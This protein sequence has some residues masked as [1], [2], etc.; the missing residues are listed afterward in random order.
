[1]SGKLAGRTAVITGGAGGIGLAIATRLAEEGANIAVADRK[2]S[3]E[4]KAIVESA[5]SRFLG[6]QCDISDESE[7]KKFAASVRETLGPADI[8]VNNAVIYRLFTFEELSFEDWKSFFAVNIHSY[9]LTAKAFLDDL[10]QSTC[11]RIINMSSTSYWLGAPGFAPYVSAKG[12][13]MGFTSALAADLGQYEIT[14]NAVAPS[15]VRTPATRNEPEEVFAFIKSRQ[16]LPRE[17]SAEDVANMV[18][19]LA[20][21]EA[22]FVTGQ[23]MVVDGG[24][25]RR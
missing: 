12:A 9:F 3:D 7:V 8:I 22:A 2:P 13:V 6:A 17:Q 11:G 18:A 15:L 24:L 21:D 23:V 10:K 20:S 14:V 25:T 1:M 16:S 4:A 5:G 19:F